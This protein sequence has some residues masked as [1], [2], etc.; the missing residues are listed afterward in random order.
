MVGGL[1]LASVTSGQLVSRWGRYKVFPVVGT[2][3]VVVGLYLLSRISLTTGGLTIASYLLV[4]GIG[5]GL[6]LQVLVV[7]VQNAVPYEHLGTAT[8][9]VTFFRSIGGSIGTAVF[10]AIFANL[11]ANNV[12]HA[13]HL[14][15]I[16]RNL[17]GALNAANP[18]SL[19]HLPPAVHAGVV[20]GMVHTIQTL[21]LISAPIAAVAFTL[22]WFLPDVELR[23][24]LGTD[25]PVEES[26]ARSSLEGMQLAVDRL[27]QR[28]NRRRLYATLAERGGLRLEPRSCWLLFRLADHPDCTIERVATRL[29]VEPR[30]IERLVEALV[31]AGLVEKAH[32]AGECEF[33][34]TKRGR[35][36]VDRLLQIRRAGFSELLKGRDL[37][38][39]PEIGEMIRQLSCYLLADDAILLDDA[40]TARSSPL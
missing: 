33:S 3:F 19:A 9:G 2:F 28:E 11:L 16:S 39:H 26:A 36:A 12:T 7:A 22:S 6:V 4:F 20:S 30:D 31:D 35:Q 23:K 21:F 1:L 14:N 13:L 18:T 37:E 27:A 5:L 10:G 24:T 38:T 40:T 32:G 25:E 8:S 29:Q 15:A 34:L 17:R